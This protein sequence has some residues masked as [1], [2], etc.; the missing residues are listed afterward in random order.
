MGPYD[1]S[2]CNGIAFVAKKSPESSSAIRVKLP[3]INTDPA[4]GV[5]EECYNDF[6]IGLKVTDEWTRYVVSFSDLK[7][8]SGWGKPN[9]P[10]IDSEKVFGIQWQTTVPGVDFDIWIDDISFVDC[11]EK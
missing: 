5:C 4:G 7:Q 11:G 6:G 8:E 1:A 10:N 2:R 3:D 9:P